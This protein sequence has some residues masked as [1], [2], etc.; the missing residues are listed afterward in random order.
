[1]DGYTPPHDGVLFSH[2]NECS[3]DSGPVSYV[4][5]PREHYAKW[6]NQVTKTTY[7]ILFIQN[8]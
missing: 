8:F 6:K 5:E 7:A 2:D 4:D 3:P 1:M